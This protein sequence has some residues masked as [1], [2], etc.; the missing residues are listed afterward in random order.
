METLLL[1]AVAVAV[2]SL[3]ATWFFCMRPMRRGR[4]PGSGGAGN[5]DP[6]LRRQIG[7]LTDEIRVLRAQDVL[8]E[9]RPVGR[10]GDG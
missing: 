4:C 2:A 9:D 7:E 5:G 3:A 8:T 10:G 6:E 1:A